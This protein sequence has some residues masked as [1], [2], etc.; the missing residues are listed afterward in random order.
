MHGSR[1]TLIPSLRERLYQTTEEHINGGIEI[2]RRGFS[3]FRPTL[4]LDLIG[5]A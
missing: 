2:F 3:R 1:N 4:G 5:A